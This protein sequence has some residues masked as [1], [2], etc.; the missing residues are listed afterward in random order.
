M[1]NSSTTHWPA[2]VPRPDRQDPYLSVLFVTI[3]VRDQDRSLQFCVGQLGF[4][5]VFDNRIDGYG[6]FVVV[7]PPGGTV[8]LALLRPEPETDEFQLV[9]RSR[10][11]VLIIE[12]IGNSYVEW[13]KPGV[14]VL[15]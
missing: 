15:N 8:D 4:N 11:W 12:N 5:M 2:G 13:R 10:E 6:R 14:G 9:G 3:F 1:A 7:A